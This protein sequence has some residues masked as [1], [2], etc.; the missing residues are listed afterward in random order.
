M[1]S[2]RLSG[3]FHHP[4]LNP[5][6]QRGNERDSWPEAVATVAD[7]FNLSG[8]WDK[9]QATAAL[10]FGPVHLLGR[11]RDAHRLFQD[12]DEI[13]ARRYADGAP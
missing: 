12:A 13:C 1:S 6:A 4:F 7:C 8:M 3:F 5:W 2:G 11:W 10:V 9:S